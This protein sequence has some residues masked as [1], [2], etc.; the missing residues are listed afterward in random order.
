MADTA[1]LQS[2]A[3]LPQE[4]LSASK[5]LPRVRAVWFALVVL[6]FV[7]FIFS[8]PD[9]YHMLQTVCDPATQACADWSQPTPGTVETLDAYGISLQAAAIYHLTLYVIVSLVFW[10]AGLLVLR[11]RSHDWHGLLVS[12]LLITSGAGGVSFVFMQGPN[13]S[14]LPDILF[15]VSG[16]TIF[17]MYLALSLFFLTFP[18]GRIY[19]RWTQATPL[20]IL[21]NY[22]VWLAP[23]SLNIMQWPSV[24]S[25]L[26]ILF[27]FGSHVVVQGVRYRN[28]YTQEQRQQTKWLIYGFGLVLAIG[29]ISS[30]L[31]DVLFNGMLEGTL[32][33]LLY[34]PIAIAVSMAIL[35]YRLWDIDIIISRTLVYA[36]LTALVAGIYV[37][38]VGTL[39]AF[40]E[41]NSDSIAI[42]L[43]ATGVVA[44]I[45]QPMREYLQRVV[46]H[47]VFGERNNPYE[48][49]SRLSAQLEANISPGTLLPGIAETV[50]Q[51][52]KLPYVAIAFKEGEGF[53]TDAVWGQPSDR[54]RITTLLLIYGQETVGQMV[55]GQ[56]AGDKPLNNAE[57]Q[58]LENIARQTGVV[59]HAVQLTAELQQ[60][61]LHIVT[62]RE[63]ERRRLRR[64]LHDGLGPT[65]ASHSLKIGAARALIENSPDVAATI[66]ADLEN[67]LATSLADI[68]RL[69]YNLRPPALDQLGLA[70]AVCDFI[71]QYHISDPMG[72]GPTFTINI[73][74]SL[75]ALPAAVEVAAYRIMQEASNNVIRHAQARHAEITVQ[76]N[77]ALDITI[78]DDGRGLPEPIHYGVGLNSMRERAE[79]LGGYCTIENRP[80]GGTHLH[81]RIP[82]P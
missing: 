24:L 64:D 74:T 70:G 23:G 47:I 9:T 26:W 72:E 61:R 77:G 62:A 10:G 45:F 51:T 73:S 16:F 50:A 76:M 69:V 31:G 18:D 78:A 58:L 29:M 65:L 42:S 30:V 5:W 66:L 13:N 48:V 7:T 2:D 60:S 82:L 67:S 39:S 32:V 36:L 37:L 35:R 19:P 33:A 28:F 57:Q 71:E 34:L 53:K 12:Y 63:E 46:D 40:F 79:E 56:V 21:A 20:L 43:S 3:P 8:I 4:L 6:I 11:H 38:I 49:I 14:V 59:V 27:V 1:A 44:I 80:S 52:L 41:S 75:P 17:P 22:G 25:G 15:A 54:G 55:I 68:R 81:A